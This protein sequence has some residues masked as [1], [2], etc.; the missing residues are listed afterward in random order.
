MFFPVMESDFNYIA[1]KLSDFLLITDLKGNIRS[2]NKPFLDLLECKKSDLLGKSFKE[3]FGEKNLFET[4]EFNKAI[5]VPIIYN[6]RKIPLR[7]SS[8]IIFRDEEP[9]GYCIVARDMRETTRLSTSL[10]ELRQTMRKKEEE[11]STKL[12]FLSDALASVGESVFITDGS[13]IIYGNKTG[14]LIFGYDQAELIGKTPDLLY[15]SHDE[16]SFKGNWK[17]E[18]IALKK[19]GTKFPALLTT[20]PIKNKIGRTIGIVG[21]FRDISELKILLEELEELSVNLEHR[22]LA[23]TRELEESRVQLLQSSKMAAIGTLAAGIAHELNNPLTI[24][25]GYC[26]LL[27]HEY[28]WS[29]EVKSWLDKIY[30]QCERAKKIVFNLSIFARSHKTEKKYVNP[31]DLLERVMELRNYELSVKN[32]TIKKKFQDNLPDIYVDEH[33]MQQVFLNLINNAVDAILTIKE[34]GIIAIEVMRQD[35]NLVLIVS[36]DG[37]G[38]APENMKKI[39]DPFYTTKEVGKGTGLG[40]SIS[41]GIIKAHN[42]EISVKST[43][44]SGTDFVVELPI[45]SYVSERS[46]E[47]ISLP[48]I[49][50]IDTVGNILVIDDEEMILEVISKFLGRQGYMVE[51][52]ENGEDAIGLIK[53]KHFDLVISDYRMPGL[54]G[55]EFYR[56]LSLIRPDLAEKLIYITGEI[57]DEESISFMKETGV[58]VLY[59]PF[60]IDELVDIVNRIVYRTDN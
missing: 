15:K 51:V 56:E 16:A 33:Q 45:T 41:Y 47:K 42:G 3:I 48:V 32:I 50:S 4:M 14:S 1:D 57:M 11:S 22:V 46:R 31:L 26:H 12:T 9:T 36:D 27:I 18:V 58:R 39:F 24:I 44:G 35:D 54:G 28:E 6:N 34:R 25:T 2:I 21:V 17:G 20:S 30:E 55:V 60:D 29:D 5:M 53:D 52:V 8:S 13:R 23:R 38:I 59:K 49:P 43:P 19:E 7:L 37:V 40:L 10:K